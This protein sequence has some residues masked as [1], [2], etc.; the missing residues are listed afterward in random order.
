MLGD[1]GELCRSMAGGTGLAVDYAVS[2][3]PLQLS[4]IADGNDKQWCPTSYPRTTDDTLST[5]SGEL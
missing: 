5:W 1:G 4:S 2:A 3:I